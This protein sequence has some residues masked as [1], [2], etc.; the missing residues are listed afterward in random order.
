MREAVLALLNNP[1]FWGFL[2]TFVVAYFGY[3]QVIKKTPAGI[4]RQKVKNVSSFE[5]LRA[6]VEVLQNELV[7]KDK[8]HK[9]DTD[10]MLS[11]LTEAR[12]EARGY[13]LKLAGALKS[14]AT[15]E[16]KAD[17]CQSEVER[18]RKLLLAKGITE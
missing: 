13:S 2:G 18:L 14:A 10:Y 1:A 9:D 5:E 6:V 8:R 3:K 11:Q 12:G 4:A 15:A 17:R 7:K 16:A